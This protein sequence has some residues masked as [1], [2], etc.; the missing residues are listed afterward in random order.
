MKDLVSKIK[1]FLT[2]D[3]PVGLIH[4]TA[5]FLTIHQY[6]R[7]Q[8][9]HW[10][11]AATRRKLITHFWFRYV[12]FHYG[13]ILLASVLLV[14]PSST[15]ILSLLAATL[16]T[17]TVTLL[18]LVLF[19]YLP[20]F[21][22]EFLPKLDTIM[23]EQEAIIINAYE[24]KKCKRTQFSIPTLTII[25]YVLSRAAQIP[26]LPSNDHSAA[27]LNNLYG[28]DKDKLKQNLSRLYKMSQLSVRERAE[29]QKG[30]VAARNFFTPLGHKPAESILDQLE[31][32]LNRAI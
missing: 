26:L 23:A 5:Q 14:I 6:Y 32:K 24:T 20:A 17:G 22:S 1:S 10:S 30:I 11:L 15:G 2:F 27:L 7:R 21:Y 28:V 31:I 29:I 16:F 13:T 18:T 19:Q 9:P 4:I 12:L 8:F 25:F 3:F